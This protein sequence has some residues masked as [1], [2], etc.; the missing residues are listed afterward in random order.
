MIL[1]SPKGSHQGATVYTAI[2][3]I[4]CFSSSLMELHI[5]QII[6]QH[7]TQGVKFSQVSMAAI[8]VLIKT[9]A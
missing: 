8:L 7:N 4:L 1:H 6:Y 9:G 3:V 2:V 5:F